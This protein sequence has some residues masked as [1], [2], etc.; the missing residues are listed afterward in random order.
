MRWLSIQQF[1][2]VLCGI[3]SGIVILVFTQLYAHE[4]TTDWLSTGTLVEMKDLPKTALL[5]VYD[6]E[7]ELW[8]RA[9]RET[10]INAKCEHIRG[11]VT[12]AGRK[13]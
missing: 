7:T 3:I 2:A 6:E 11:I 13:R 1:V 4:S 10:L 9:R 12:M 5:Y 8:N